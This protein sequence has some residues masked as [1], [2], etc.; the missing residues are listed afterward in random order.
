M[1]NSR[2]ASKRLTKGC[3]QVAGSMKT[4]I[5]PKR[6]HYT[7]IHVNNWGPIWT[8]KVV[9]YTYG[10]DQW[11]ALHSFVK[12]YF[13][14]GLRF[15]I[16]GDVVEVKMFKNPF[17]YYED[18]SPGP[19]SVFKKKTE[20]R[21]IFLVWEGRYEKKPFLQALKDQFTHYKKTTFY[22]PK[23]WFNKV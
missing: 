10:L 12:E 11:E 5:T 3:A 6:E 13:E 14:P 4:N 1:S 9:D 17:D 16:Q 7:I 23:L 21:E 22:K 8:W 19:A 2:R 15:E 20:K 18:C